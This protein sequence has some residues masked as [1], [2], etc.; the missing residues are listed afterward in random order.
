MVQA[1]RLNERPRVSRLGIHVAVHR[2]ALAS[3][4]EDPVH[5]TPFLS[6]AQVVKTWPRQGGLGTISLACRLGTAGVLWSRVGVT[7]VMD[8]FSKHMTSPGYGLAII[9]G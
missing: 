9:S 4:V 6:F 5:A 1:P 8:I 7:W 3:V 2:E